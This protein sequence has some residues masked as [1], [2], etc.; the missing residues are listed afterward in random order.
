MNSPDTSM[1]LESADILCNIGYDP[2]GRS[3]NFAQDNPDKLPAQL[4]CSENGED[5]TCTGDDATT[6]RAQPDRG[7]ASEGIGSNDTT[8]ETTL[9]NR[10]QP[11]VR[12]MRKDLKN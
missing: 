5:A 2:S 4:Q 10:D 6:Q 8:T 1:S 7:E 9:D 3:A 11:Q 12:L